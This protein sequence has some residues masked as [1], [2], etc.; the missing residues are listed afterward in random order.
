MT[1][2]KMI[3]PLLKFTLI[4]AGTVLIITA[5]MAWSS[6]FVTLFLAFLLAVSM[7]PLKGWFEGKGLSKGLAVII[8]ILIVMIVIAGMVGFLILSVDRLASV[9]PTYADKTD[10]LKSGLQGGISNLGIDTSGIMNL[11]NID[12]SVLL[13]AAAKFLFGLI[14]GLASLF[15]ILLIFFFGLVEASTFS[16]EFTQIFDKD[17]PMVARVNELIFELREYIAITTKINLVIAAGDTI[18]LIILGVPFPFL[19]GTLS[20]FTGF[21]PVVGFWISMI[22]PLIL[23][24]LALGP[25][26]ALVI[27]VGYIVI[28]GGIQN[29]L[30]PRLYGKGL[31][32]NPLVIVLSLILWSWILGPVGALIA[33]P[34]TLMVMRLLLE[35]FDETKSIAKMMGSEE[36]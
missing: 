18:L 21:I 27:L 31:N 17:N 8:T 35:S 25:T 30:E 7:D 9:L 20:F 28:N 16:E 23:A 24:V 3:S 32:L 6:M 22:P 4:A 2:Q 12:S 13:G 19:W 5:M 15:T 10:S 14:S 33:V 36:K 11:K 29:F 34:M 1:E 26:Q